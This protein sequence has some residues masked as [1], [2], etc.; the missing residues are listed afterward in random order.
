MEK[1]L[2]QVQRKNAYEVE[3]IHKEHQQEL[4]VVSSKHVFELEDLKLLTN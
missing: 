1:D 2:G 4:Q 3:R